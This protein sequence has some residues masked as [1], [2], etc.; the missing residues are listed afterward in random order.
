MNY[1]ARKPIINFHLYSTPFSRIRQKNV[2]NNILTIEVLEYAV[3]RPKQ[4]IVL[5]Y[6]SA[7]EVAN[8][9]FKN[10]ATGIHSG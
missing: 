10:I 8:K 1:L 6:H 9:S 3:N 4:P 7:R 5:P 2:L